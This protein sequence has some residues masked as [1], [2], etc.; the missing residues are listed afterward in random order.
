MQHY[1]NGDN[2]IHHVLTM[3]PKR[4]VAQARH[5]C[6]VRASEA[7][8]TGAVYTTGAGDNHLAL[9]S[10]HDVRIH[11]ARVTLRRSSE[12][13]QCSQRGKPCRGTPTPLGA[14]A[15]FFLCCNPPEPLVVL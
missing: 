3:N 9:H 1:A 12:A 4:K 2:D 6:Q 15:P 10:Y 14:P 7:P 5:L 11:A 8:R 13:V